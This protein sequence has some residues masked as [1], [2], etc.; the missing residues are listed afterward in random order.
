MRTR[1]L[2]TAGIV[3][4][5]LFVTVVALQLATRDGFDLSHHPI[6]LLTLGDA[7]WVQVANFVVAGV[8]SGA[9]AVGLGRVLVSGPGHR[10]APRL[11]FV[12][13]VGLVVGGLFRPDPALGYP[14]GTPDE[15]PD[16]ISWHGWLHAVAPP[17]AFTALVAA[18]VVL[19]RRDRFLG[20]RG[21]ARYSAFTAAAALL[22]TAWPHPDSLSWRLA[23]G[24]VIGF[25]W[26][27]ALALRERAAL[28]SSEAEQEAV[29]A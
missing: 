3:A 26:L 7:G 29:A 20:R 24:V 1:H 22:V 11:L 6:S 23:I 27:T 18:A 17:L 5:P 10:W 13:G 12:Y 2:L 25:A 9:F 8:L 16:S 4:G 14:V 28:V 19:A 21:W 15:V